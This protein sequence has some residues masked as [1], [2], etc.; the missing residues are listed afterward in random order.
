MKKAFLSVLALATIQL[1]GCVSDNSD[2][3]I[4]VSWTITANNQPST[5]AAVGAST[6][7]VIVREGGVVLAQPSFACTAGGAE[8][9][10]APGTYTVQL[11]IFDSGNQ[12]L[13]LVPFNMSA[14]VSSGRTVNLG[15]AEFAFTLDFDASFRVQ[16]GSTNESCSSAGIVQEEIRIST[17]GQCLDVDL[18]V[19]GSSEATCTRYVCEEGSVLRTLQNLPPNNYLV[20]VIGWKGA[21]S[22]QPRACYYS[23]AVACTQASCPTTITSFFDPLPADEQFCNAT[24]PEPDTR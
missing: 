6:V 24:K 7:R 8:L 22:A 19:G 10:I 15:N 21:T 5:C 20:Q 12:Q 3:S 13:N 4:L 23:D 2:G 14:T 9:V 17:G 18:L 1:S 11:D 16:W